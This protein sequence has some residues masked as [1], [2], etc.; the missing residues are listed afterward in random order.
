MSLDQF[1]DEP[2][3]NSHPSYEQSVFNIRPAPEFATAEVIVASL[4]RAIGFKDVTEKGVPGAGR[5]FDKLAQ[6]AKPP[7]GLTPRVSP[8]TWRTIIHGVLESPKQQNQSAKR[9]LQLSPVVPDTARYS[10]S[11]RLTGNSWNPGV[12]VQRMIRIGTASEEDASSIWRALY[13]ALSVG[14]T[15]DVWARWLQEEFQRWSK[16]GATWARQELTETA[17]LPPADWARLTFPAKQFVRD[18]AAIV[19]AKGCMTR[20][21]WVSLLEAVLRL[22]AVA[23][24][25]WLCDVNDRCWRALRHTILGEQLPGLE[26][27]GE[28]LIAG[29]RGY[30][31]YGTPAVPDIRD[32]STRYLN[33]RLGINLLLWHLEAAGVGVRPL[34]ASVD[35][36]GLIDLVRAKAGMLRAADV[37]GQFGTLQD[38]YSRTIACKKGIGS[39]L[40][41]FGRHTLGQRVTAN[42][43]QRGYDQGYV[44]R[45]K[46]DYST[47]PWIV[48]LGPVALLALVHCCLSEV[49]GPRSVQRLA[50]HLGL[51]GIDVDRDD[52]TR[53]DLGRQLRMLGLVLD[54]PDAESGML[55]VPPFEGY[56]APAGG[57]AL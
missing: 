25:L 20:R 11:A 5:E 22:G 27:I 28:A 2:W 15:D 3:K 32:F 16:A 4:Y 44:L 51:Y 8:D 14:P 35:I 52:L 49:S 23:H 10:G 50:E 36:G 40:V 9:F 21:Q 30:L 19:R 57:A 12:L 54:S 53:S 38:E 29:R 45:K 41:E 48:S 43:S 37:L 34:N 46:G 6:R 47:A 39:N 24:V 31:I 26:D 33:A 42:D 13:N 1:A 56:N 18:L 7:A 17:H 55:L